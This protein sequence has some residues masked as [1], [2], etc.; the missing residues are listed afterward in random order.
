M[1]VA[2]ELFEHTFQT[3]AGEVGFLAEVRV[4]ATTLWLKDI[5]VYPAQAGELQLGTKETRNCLNQIKKW[6]LAAAFSELRITGERVSGASK[7]R[8]VRITR[9]LQ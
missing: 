3:H 6:A 7:G 9:V 5:A 2:G 4:I 1:F 8:A